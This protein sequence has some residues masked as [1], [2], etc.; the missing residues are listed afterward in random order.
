M[1]DFQNLLL[2]LTATLGKE[3]IGFKP[4]SLTSTLPYL[5]LQCSSL[6]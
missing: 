3:V 2:K 1:S 6:T 4:L 5:V